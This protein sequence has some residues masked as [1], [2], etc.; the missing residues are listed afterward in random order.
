MIEHQ[1]KYQ[2]YLK[3]QGVGSRDKVA[4]SIKSYLSYLNSVSNYLNITIGPKT[5]SSEQDVVNLSI[6]LRGK[7][8]DKSIK[9]YGS[10]MKQYVSMVQSLGL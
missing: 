1:F 4:D 10:A 9:N 3:T 2:Q 8:S 6:K 7:V 5:L